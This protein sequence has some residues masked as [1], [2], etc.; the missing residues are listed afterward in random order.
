MLTAGSGFLLLICGFSGNSEI[1]QG[2]G[3]QNVVI[4]SAGVAFDNSLTDVLGYCQ[5]EQFAGNLDVSGCQEANKLPVVLQLPEGA[6]C[7]DGAIHPEQLAFFRGD[8]A[9]GSFPIFGEFPADHQFLPTFRI[10]GLT[11][12]RSVGTVAAVLTSVSGD[13]SRRS[14]LAVFRRCAD[15]VQNPPVLTQV[16]V[17]R[18]IVAHVFGPADLRLEFS[19]PTALV[20]VRL[21]KCFLLV[22]IQVSVVLKTLI[23]GIGHNLAKSET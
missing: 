13:F 14:V 22:L 6:L 20:I 7:L 4:Q 1:Q 18:R 9:K 11:A 19:R 5:Q 21:D 2:C 12:G 8:P 3:L 23:S 17:S 15:V 16:V 10:P